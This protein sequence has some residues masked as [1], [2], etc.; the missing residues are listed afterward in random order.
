MLQVTFSIL[1]DEI[2]FGLQRKS[3]F[4]RK[5]IQIFPKEGSI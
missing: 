3:F 1:A 5:A 4:G 2:R